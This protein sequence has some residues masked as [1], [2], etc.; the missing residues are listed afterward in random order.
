MNSCSEPVTSMTLSNHVNLQGTQLTLVSFNPFL[1]KARTH[2]E[3]HT[4]MS[5][6]HAKV[7]SV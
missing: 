5:S 1:V 2:A 3:F 7:T 4:Y 6:C